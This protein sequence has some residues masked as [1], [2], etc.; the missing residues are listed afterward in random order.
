ME[1][2]IELI[3]HKKPWG[4]TSGDVILQAQLEIT[5]LNTPPPFETQPD[6]PDMAELARRMKDACEN[7]TKGRRKGMMISSRFRVETPNAH[8]VIILHV[9]NEH[10]PD[11][12]LTFKRM[13]A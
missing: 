12:F 10:E 7:A 3:I 9:L 1:K 2:A 11:L 5:E 6:K 8:T 4:A 13:G